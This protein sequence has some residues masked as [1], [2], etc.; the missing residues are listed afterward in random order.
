MDMR[1]LTCENVLQDHLRDLSFS[2]RQST[3][4]VLKNLEEFRISPD[5]PESTAYINN[6]HSIPRY[7]FSISLSFS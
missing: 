7:F 6:R 1:L 4:F 2:R 3:H 5:G